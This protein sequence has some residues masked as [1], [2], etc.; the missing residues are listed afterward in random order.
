MLSGGALALG[1][2]A[3]AAGALPGVSGLGFDLPVV[4]D[5]GLV[6]TMDM[7][8]AVAA[9]LVVLPAIVVKF[10]LTEKVAVAES[11][12]GRVTRADAPA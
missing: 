2:L 9:A 6:A 7:I 10:G 8:L 11:K 12:E 5:F 4:R 1:F 3:L